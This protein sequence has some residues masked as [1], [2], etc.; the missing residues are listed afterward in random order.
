ME[1]AKISPEESLH[2]IETMINTAKNRFSENG[3]MYLVWGWTVFICSLSQFVLLH[4]Y[5]YE[6]HYIVW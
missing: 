3:H 4:F 2:L 5:S 1:E 6:R